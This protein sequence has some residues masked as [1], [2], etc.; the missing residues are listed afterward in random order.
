MKARNL[1]SHNERVMNDSA[2]K[3]KRTKLEL[4]GQALRKKKLANFDKRA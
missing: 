3:L 4:R 1:N 2:T